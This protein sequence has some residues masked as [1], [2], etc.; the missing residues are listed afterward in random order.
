MVIMDLLLDL[1]TL[2]TLLVPLLLGIVALRLWV[3]FVYMTADPESTLPLPPGGVGLPFVGETLELLFKVRP[4][5]VIL[6]IQ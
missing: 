6:G 4:Y 5:F 3:C 2:I 1:T